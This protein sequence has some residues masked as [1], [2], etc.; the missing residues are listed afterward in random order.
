MSDGEAGGGEERESERERD[1]A[2]KDIKGE[3]RKAR[4][5][6]ARG[7]K[8]NNQTF[9]QESRGLLWKPTSGRALAM[10]VK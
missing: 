5:D 3:R 10:A 1:R 9:P 7:R 4:V 2:L 8:L 6:G